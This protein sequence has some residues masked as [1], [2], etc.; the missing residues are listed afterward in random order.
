MKEDFTPMGFSSSGAF[1]GPVVFAGY[2]IR[3][4]ELDYDDYAGIDVEGKV[5]LALRYEP[6][7]KDEES[8]FDGKRASRWSDLRY[9]ALKAREAGA[10][11]LVFVTGPVGS[12]PDEPDSLPPL[13]SGGPT[14]RAGL[15]VLQVT[16]AVASA[17]LA[18]EGHD[19][20]T[21]Q[22]AIDEDYAPRSV[23]LP[24]L[25]V[26]GTVDVVAT[27]AQVSN[28]VG[29]LPG[30]G[31]L[32]E[33]VVVV[34]AHYDHLGYG[35]DRSMRP[36]EEAIHN[37]ADDNASGVA[38]MLCG[39]GDLSEDL[40][41]ASERRTLVALAFAAEEIGV[42]G[43][44]WYTRHPLFPLEQTVA[45]VNL[46]MV[47]RVRD[48][49]L[50]VLGTDSA[51]EWED[52]LRPHAQAAGLEI[53]TGGDGYGPSDQMP[54]YEKEVPVI[55]LF[56]GAHEEYHTPDDDSETLNMEGGDQVAGFLADLVGSLVTADLT[57][58][59]RASTT[60]PTMAGDSRGYGAYLGTIPDYSAMMETEG[61]V[62]LSDVRR[63]GPA[64]RA[65]IRGGDRIVDMA[66]VE[67]QNLY[68][69]TFVLR[70]NRPGESI[71]V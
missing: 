32:A 24:S 48:G 10:A 36:D 4:E 9:K 20:G 12:D 53:T 50:Q 65:G 14:S 57:L 11:A 71:E 30:R 43:S 33:E 7:E 28:V 21:L 38:A 16:R 67:I 45:M 40:R 51:P 52:L 46:D 64:D 37:G 66:G 2:G 15:P 59:W 6:G 62:L 23:D 34:G 60:G 70:D 61:G 1:G 58:T 56:S 3:A 42:G 26:E 44:N 47:G 69:M 8:P 19:L 39:V 68:D 55:H 13:K 41:T 31:D 29:V 17:W 63:D 18:S 25:R 5:V 49:A 22:A 35:G 54:F 27:T